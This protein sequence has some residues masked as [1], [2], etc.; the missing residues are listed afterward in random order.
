MLL[1]KCVCKFLCGIYFYSLEH[2]PKNGFPSCLACKKLPYLYNHS[3]IEFNHGLP[4]MGLH[5]VGHVWRNLAAAAAAAAA[6]TGYLGSYQKWGSGSSNLSLRSIPVLKTHHIWKP[7]V[8]LCLGVHLVTLLFISGVSIFDLTDYPTGWKLM[9]VMCKGYNL[10][11][12][13]VAQSHPTLCNPMDCSPPGSSVHGILQARILEWVA[14]PF[15]STTFPD[16]GLNLGLLCC[17]RFF[18]TWATR[19]AL[20]CIQ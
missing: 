18:T 8:S 12:L 9:V 11:V 19:G 14:I 10:C 5:R 13:L 15:S 7:M 3:S 20:Q 6:V 2:R 4:S 16:P 1:W 17:S